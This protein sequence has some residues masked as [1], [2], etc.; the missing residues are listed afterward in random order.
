MVKKRLVVI[1]GGAA[2]FFCAIN[3]AQMNPA[4][5]VM[6]IEKTSKLLSKVRISGGGRCN[7][8]HHCFSMAEM[9]KKYPR[10]NSFLKKAFHHFFTTDTIQW[11]NE[12]GVQLKAEADGRMFPVTDSSETIVN[13]LMK[14]VNKYG[15]QILLNREVAALSMVN[16][17]WSVGFKDGEKIMT[18][19]VCVASGGYPKALQFE[20]LKKLGHTIE[21]PV[22]SLFTFN[23][24]GN[25]ITSLMGIVAENASV[26]IAGSKLQEQGPL[27]ITHWGMSGPCI[28]KLSAWG[29]KEL[30]AKNYNFSI[31]VNWLPAF[32]E[33]T[34]KDKFQQVRFEQAAQKIVNRNAF[35]LPQRLWQ[36]L[37]QQS[38]VNENLRWADL[39]AKEQNRLIK[40]ICAQEFAVSGKTTFKEEFVTAGGVALEEVD[41]NTMQS[42]IIPNLFFAGEVLNIDGV[43]GGFNFQSAWTTG[44]IA[45]KAITGG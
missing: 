2:G 39:P 20:W 35:G 9:I 40:N 37:L 10:G 3:A 29:A 22:P 38:G 1:G 18:D 32:N 7:V 45:A 6:I 12:R 26:K 42:K 8:T 15:V 31:L 44:Y 34:L 30:A 5:E 23:M 28:L 13:C 41:Y 17:E 25:S 19:F 27:L 4:L 24:P 33:Q 11:F 16:G 21:A 36:Y 14:E 43:T